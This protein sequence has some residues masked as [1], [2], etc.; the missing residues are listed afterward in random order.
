MRPDGVQL[1]F[2]M[3][4]F[5]ETESTH[6]LTTKCFD[7]VHDFYLSGDKVEKYKNH[8]VYL[9]TPN[10]I[11]DPKS[12]QKN[13]NTVKDIV[14]YPVFLDQNNTSKEIKNESKMTIDDRI[15]ELKNEIECLDVDQESK[16]C[17]P[18][19]RRGKFYC[20]AVIVFI[21]IVLGTILFFLWPR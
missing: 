21:L 20:L 3:N 12:N 13:D 16:Y 9:N 4:D 17:F 8:I 2:K 18:K 1:K 14:Q 19:D 15:L 11:Y 6:D 5:E 10:A 7:I